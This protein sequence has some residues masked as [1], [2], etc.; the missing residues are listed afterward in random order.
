[1]KKIFPND[2]Q[3]ASDPFVSFRIVKFRDRNVI[4]DS[5]KPE[6]STFVVNGPNARDRVDT[7]DWVHLP[8]PMSM[9]N[10]YSP[11]WEMADMRLIEAARDALNAPDKMAGAG[12]LF[13][14]GHAVIAGDLTKKL[15][16]KT[17]NPKKQALF[18]GI[19]PRNFTFSWQFTP[20]T[21]RESEQ[22]QE[23]IRTF[24]SNALP[25]KANESFF[26]FPAEF[27]ISFTN[28]KG[29]PKLSY[30]V[31]TGVATDLTPQSLQLLRSGHPVSV[32]F[33][34]SFME[35]DLRTKER[36]GI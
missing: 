21:E 33:S 25:E 35:T 9:Q 19:D 18:N 7:L 16:F 20:Q 28:V 30:C 5:S 34:L 10:N 4:R 12:V 3:Q 29:Y 2:L 8:L 14:F 24:V 17:P 15:A 23:I 6:S 26:N 32:G 11:N 22:I 27:L 36:P 31:C 1:M 13:D